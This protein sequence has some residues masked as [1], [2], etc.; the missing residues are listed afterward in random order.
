MTD[1][2]LIMVPLWFRIISLLLFLNRIKLFKVFQVSLELY[3]HPN[4]KNIYD[5]ALALIEIM[6]GSMQGII[7]ALLPFWQLCIILEMA[8]ILSD[9]CL[10]F[11]TCTTHTTAV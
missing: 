7:A 1:G 3:E 10:G 4:H 5:A 9:K 2:L 11:L 8:W 6:Y